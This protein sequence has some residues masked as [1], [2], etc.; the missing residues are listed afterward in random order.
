MKTNIISV[1]IQL[2]S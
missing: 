1:Q 2:P